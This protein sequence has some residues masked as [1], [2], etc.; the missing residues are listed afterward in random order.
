MVP[1]REV[2]FEQVVSFLDFYVRLRLDQGRMGDG[3][4]DSNRQ[5]EAGEDCLR[6]AVLCDWYERG[7]LAARYARQA[8]D[9]D[10]QGAARVKRLLPQ[11]QF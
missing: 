10:P 3:T 2:A 7:T 6:L 4:Q 11:V 1:W 5:R 9:V 8:V